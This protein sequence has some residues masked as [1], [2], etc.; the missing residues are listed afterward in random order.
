M[1]LVHA[2]LDQ[3]IANSEQLGDKSALGM[4]NEVE[5]P[6]LM[7]HYVRN[8]F[9]ELP[10]KYEEPIFLYEQEGRVQ[11]EETDRIRFSP[12]FLGFLPGPELG[13][14]VY[15]KQMISNFALAFLVDHYGLSE[16]HP[17]VQA[18]LQS[19]PAQEITCE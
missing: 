8:G 16:D 2:C 3:V 6:N 5:S 4:V 15:T 11:E 10:V 14:Q 19:I 17:I 12:M 18:A 13:T 1:Y 9:V 7:Q